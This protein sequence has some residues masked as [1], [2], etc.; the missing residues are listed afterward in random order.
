MTLTNSRLPIISRCQR[1]LKIS[2]WQ[3]ENL[4]WSLYDPCAYGSGGKIY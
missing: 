2:E 1:Q 4:T 3:P